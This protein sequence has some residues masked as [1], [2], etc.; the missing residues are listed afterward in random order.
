M[1]GVH[2]VFGAI[3]SVA[4]VV[5][6]AAAG[7]AAPIPVFPGND[8]FPGPLND[9]PSLAKCDNIAEA[10][11]F[12]SCGFGGSDWEDGAA[13]GDYSGA[14]SVTFIDE[15]S[16]TWEFDPSLVTGTASPLFPSLL[17]VMGG[18]NYKVLDI[19]GLLNGSW[20][21]SGLSAGASGNEPGVSHLSFYDTGAVIPLPA[22]LPL[23]LGGLA[24]L[25]L[26]GWRR[27]AT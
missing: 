25:G 21:T 13:P 18:N 27:K 17:A 3:A 10:D 7:Q 23:L 5:G 2:R 15:H 6:W 4:L 12:A 24:G 8:P 22:S 20:D 9:S 1:I 26:V 14:F 16:G 11:P 19:S